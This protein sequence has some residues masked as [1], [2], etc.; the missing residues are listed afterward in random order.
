MLQ[1]HFPEDE[2]ALSM[3]RGVAS[4]SERSV[5][6]MSSGRSIIYIAGMRYVLD[7]GRD[8]SRRQLGT[9]ADWFAGVKSAPQTAGQ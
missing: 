6:R 5:Y 3:K 7:T 1:Q 9:R 2:Q 8:S 4:R